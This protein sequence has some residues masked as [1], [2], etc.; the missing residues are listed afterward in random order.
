[1]HFAN[2]LP[3]WFFEWCQATWMGRWE[4][5]SKWAFAII[6]TI[7]ILGLTVLL[8]SLLVVDLRLLGLG[9]KRQ[10]VAELAR[11]LAPVTLGAIIVMILTGTSLF[12]YEAIRLS[13]SGPFF[14]K[15]VFLSL[16]LVV[17]F[18]VHRNAI[19]T[20][21]RRNVWFGKLAACLSLACWLGVALCGRGIAFLP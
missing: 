18:S 20:A 11:D 12:L 17:H 15:M 14:L 6:E 19:A 4:A 16:A 21:G 2:F 13:T 10:T 1:M 8:G 9:M 5:E 7:H 3:R